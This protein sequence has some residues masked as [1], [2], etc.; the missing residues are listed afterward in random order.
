MIRIPPRMAMIAAAASAALVAPAARAGT[1]V[2]DSRDLW[3]SPPSGDGDM[4]ARLTGA[5]A[6]FADWPAY[7]SV[8]A[9]C[10]LAVGLSWLLAN[11]AR[12]RA[13]RADLVLEILEERRALVLVGLASAVAAF[14][15]SIEPVMALVLVALGIF[16]RAEGVV[17]SPQMRARVLL[18]VG[19]GAAAGLS[20]YLLALLAALAG[21]AVLRW[22]GSARHARVKV[23]LSPGADRERAR[24]LASETLART[25][26]RVLGVREGR[27]GRALVFT[28]RVPSG[29]ADELLSKGL[30]AS[31]G[32]EIGPVAVEVQG[33]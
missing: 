5:F 4:D 32:A 6:Q 24:S 23:R 17:R 9:S 16:L 18:V 31:L 28:V 7:V 1:K 11:A 10:A 12:G 2:W 3:A 30:A 14:V 33:R 19:V 27:S 26:C 25:N 8:A 21:L 29:V 15:A 20:Q 13:G 22:L